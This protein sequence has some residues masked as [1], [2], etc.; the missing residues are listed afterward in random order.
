MHRLEE[1]KNRQDLEEEQRLSLESERKKEREREDYKKKQEEERVQQVRKRQ[2]E[3]KR[4]QVSKLDN[5]FD[6]LTNKAEEV[7]TESK[8]FYS[9]ISSFHIL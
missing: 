9:C 1:E 7:V 3:L 6:L 5:N 8:R 2:E 4:L